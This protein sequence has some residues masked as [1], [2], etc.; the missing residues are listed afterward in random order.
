M[1]RKLYLTSLLAVLI[2]FVGAT[3]GAFLK[4][5][6]FERIMP[7]VSYGIDLQ[8]GYR[9]ILD[10]QDEQLLDGIHHKMSEYVRHTLPDSTTT[11]NDTGYTATIDGELSMED[12]ANLAYES[13]EL[14]I[15]VDNGVTTLEGID[16]LISRERA[17]VIANNIQVINARLNAIGTADISVFKQG[18]NKIVVELPLGLDYEATKDLLLSTSQISFYLHSSEEDAVQG[19]Y[20]N[21]PVARASNPFLRGNSV[22]EAYAGI[23]QQ[24]GTAIVAIRL[25]SSGAA[26]MGEV[27][28]KNIGNPIITS[29]SQSVVDEDT[30]QWVFQEEIINVATIQSQLGRNFQISGLD[31]HEVA[32]SLAVQLKSGALSAPMGIVLEQTIDPRLGAEN[33]K[34]G[35]NAFLL[36]LSL[37]F[38]YIVYQYR[39]RGV[40]TCITLAVNVCMITLLLALLGAS[41][42]LTGIAGLVLTMGI[43]VDANIIVL[44]RHLGSLKGKFESLSEAFDNS[45]STVMDANITTMLASIVLFNVGSVA[46]KGFAVTLG[47]GVITTIAISFFLNR[48]ILL[49]YESTK[50][51][52]VIA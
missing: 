30:M 4:I 20:N 45:L 41:F 44:E 14:A 47:L 32:N 26:I 24:S 12:Q 46:L 2:L 1:K 40:L 43:A 18:S 52:E 39:M 31:S 15:T 22:V 42:T 13:P 34:A 36:G 17:D 33:I 9:I 27:S 5:E 7:Q 10:V 23:D 48:H 3:L 38:S 37:L 11:F 28:G 16:K 49:T 29:L 19:T 35:G 8:G 25:D 6:P 21:L 50:E 51:A